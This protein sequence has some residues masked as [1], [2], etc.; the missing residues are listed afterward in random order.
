[1]IPNGAR[2]RPGTRKRLS[3]RTVFTW[4]RLQGYK[5]VDLLVQVAA[6]M[7]GVDLVVAGEG[8]AR[9]ALEELAT[10]L[11]V[12]DRVRFL[13]RISDE[14]LGDWLASDVLVAAPSTIEAFGLT[15]ADALA[16]GR[17]VV[18]S[19]VDAHRAVAELAG[20]G[21]DIT[22]LPRSATDARHDPA[23]LVSEVAAV[24]GTALDRLGT[25]SAGPAGSAATLPTWPMVTAQVAAVYGTLPS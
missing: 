19:P 13:G 5:R 11:D 12:A 17:S 16:S 14:E 24:I 23:G 22:F 3:R 10:G 9:V 7:P 21:S 6:K 25:D 15:V 8:P 18:A 4:G 2:V 20:F 1:V